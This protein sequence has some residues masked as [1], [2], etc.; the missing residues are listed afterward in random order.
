MNETI[1]PK[2]KSFLPNNKA[3]KTIKEVATKKKEVIL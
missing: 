1:L 3:I 2:N